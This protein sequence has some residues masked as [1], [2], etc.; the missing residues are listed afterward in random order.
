MMEN[1]VG[2]IV[3]LDIETGGR[4]A[5]SSMMSRQN[6]KSLDS[7]GRAPKPAFE[8]A[9]PQTVD[10]YQ[11][12]GRWMYS[13][14]NPIVQIAAIAVDA[15]T[16]DMIEEFEVKLNFRPELATAEALE[17]NSWDWA[18]WEKDAAEYPDGLDQL[19]F[20][21]EAHRTV[22]MTSKAGKPYKVAQMA[23]HNYCDFDQEFLIRSFEDPIW[24][25]FAVPGDEPR[26]AAPRGVFFPGGFGGLD[27]L[28]LARWVFFQQSRK[29]DDFKLETLA[30]WFEIETPD[31]H[32]A[33]AD[34]RVNIEVCQHLLEVFRGA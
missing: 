18:T 16:L 4:E 20:F 9:A 1:R 6:W 22:E 29:P 3:F 31:A 27:T 13:P 24:Q 33:L 34:V 21:L 26:Q 30:K 8:T 25:L 12:L 17:V 7:R 11:A 19:V 14:G 2:K 32:D 23:G 28:H 10:G 15:V 5:R